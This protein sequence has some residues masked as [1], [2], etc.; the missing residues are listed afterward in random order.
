MIFNEEERF[1]GNLE[2][3]KNDVREVDLEELAKLLQKVTL[4]D[5]EQLPERE[6]PSS[7]EDTP[8]IPL[9]SD[10]PLDEAEDAL[11]SIDAAKFEPFPTSH[12]AC[13][14]ISCLNPTR[15]GAG[16]EH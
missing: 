12:S 11:E 9:D 8:V 4:P 15:K 14:P 5:D 6:T 7:H 2:A 13:S 3:L 1:T 10:E 16:A